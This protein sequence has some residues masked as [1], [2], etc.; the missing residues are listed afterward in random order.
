[1]NNVL[2]RSLTGG[3]FISIILLPLFFSD[4]ATTIVFGLFMAIG[5]IEFYQL[6]K[7][8][9]TVDVRW[10][11]GLFYGLFIFGLASLIFFN[12]IPQFTIVA[13]I[14]LLFSLVLLE[15]W[16][17]KE[18]PIINASVLV[19]GIFYVAIPFILMVFITVEDKNTFP[20]LAGMFI[21]TWMNDTF[22]YLSGRIAGKTKLFERISPN[23]TWEGTIGG[24]IFTVLAGVAVGYLF[25]PSHILFW[26]ISAVIIAPCAILGD[27]VESLF[28][29]NVKVKDTGN[30]MPGHGGILDRFDATFF[31]VPFFLAWA[32]IYTNL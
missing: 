21:L 17:K 32:F 29:R 14:P 10:E 19:F 27:L 2:L 1:M 12:I 30:I 4:I 28:K 11:T 23:K 7:H 9:D 15:L 24:V 26:V 8:V 6:F 25:D 13:L 22:A 5:L 16:R 20:L 31:V 18:N 3:V